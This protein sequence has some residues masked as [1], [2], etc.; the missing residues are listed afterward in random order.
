MFV[1]AETSIYVLDKLKF[2]VSSEFESSE[3]HKT[4]ETDKMQFQTLKAFVET[5]EVAVD[6][7]KPV[8]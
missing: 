5:V 8:L 3:A 4:V 2:R 1:G 7:Y 6:A